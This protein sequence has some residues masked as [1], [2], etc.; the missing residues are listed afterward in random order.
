MQARIVEL[1]NL[2][3]QSENYM[4]TIVAA[5]EQDAARI[6]ELEAENEALRQRVASLEAAVVQLSEARELVY[7]GSLKE[8]A[9][10]K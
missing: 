8:K 6:K 10:G 7:Q 4:E 9:N 5:A 1:K 3:R 2:L